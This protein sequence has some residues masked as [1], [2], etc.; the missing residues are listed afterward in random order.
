MQIDTVGQNMRTNKSEGV[1]LR[2]VKIASYDNFVW[3]WSCA[4]PTKDYV[5]LFR[6]AKFG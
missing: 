1:F 4:H 3:M 2:S 6:E 5:E